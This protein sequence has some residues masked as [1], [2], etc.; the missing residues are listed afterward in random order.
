M[1]IYASLVPTP[2]LGTVGGLC[3]TTS[4]RAE[5]A[6]LTGPGALKPMIV[7]ADIRAAISWPWLN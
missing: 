4:A 6:V 3:G 7:A 2:L 1:T 5:E